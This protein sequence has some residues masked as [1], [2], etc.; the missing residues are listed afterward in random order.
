SSIQSLWDSAGRKRSP[1]EWAL[2]WVYNHPEVSVALSGM[3]SMAQL[4]ENIKTAEDALPG[5]MSPDE[6]EL[7]M[8]VKKRYEEMLRVN[9]TGCAYC[10]PCPNGVNIPTNFDAFN[11]YYLF[12]DKTFPKIEYNVFMPEGQRASACVQCGECEE[13]CPQQISIMDELK[14]VHDALYMEHMPGP[15]F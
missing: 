10:M 6:I 2:R 7:I 14:K 11:N 9:C 1:A 3:N 4:R 12:G 5:S 13:K 15:G 8:K